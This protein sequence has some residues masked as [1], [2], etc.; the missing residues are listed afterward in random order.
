MVRYQ[1]P[2]TQDPYQEQTFNYNGRKL[3]LTL[4]YNSVGQCWAFDL[5]DVTSQTQ[6]TQGASLVCGVPL[7]WRTSLPYFLWCE[8]ESGGH[9][10]PMYLDDLGTRCFLYVTEKV[11]SK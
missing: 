9:L 7:L 11:D 5:Y 4:R 3:R 6:L 1:I 8:D 10:D 2:I